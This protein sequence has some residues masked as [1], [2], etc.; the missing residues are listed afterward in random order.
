MNQLP[1]IV[2]VADLQRNYRAV[3]NKAKSSKEAVLVVNNGKPDAVIMD[4]RT[5]TKQ[6]TKIKTLQSQQLLKLLEQALV[7]HKTGKTKKIKKEQD[8]IEILT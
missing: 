8:I 1:T 4:T 2:N 7:E 3:L 6:V 5:Y